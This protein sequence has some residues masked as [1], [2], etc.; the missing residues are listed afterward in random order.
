MPRIYPSAKIVWLLLAATLVIGRKV[1]KSRDRKHT[2]KA[3]LF[4][5]RTHTHTL[6]ILC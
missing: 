4:H 1:P 2:L 5:S 6:R 3:I